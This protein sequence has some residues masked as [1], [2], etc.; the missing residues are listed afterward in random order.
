MWERMP[1]PKPKLGA[2][3]KHPITMALPPETLI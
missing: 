1:V 2:G 3:R